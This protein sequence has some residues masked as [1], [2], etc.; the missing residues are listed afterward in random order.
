[1]RVVEYATPAAFLERVTLSL[2]AAEAENNLI[3]GVAARVHAAGSRAFVATLE[4]GG[5]LH[6]AGL[7]IGAGVEDLDV[8]QVRLEDG[9]E[10][11]HLGADDHRLRV[12]L[13]LAAV[14][15]GLPLLPCLR[16]RDQVG[17]RLVGRLIAIHFVGERGADRRLGDA[18]AQRSRHVS[19]REVTFARVEEASARP[20]PSSPT[21]RPSQRWRTA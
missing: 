11:A 5:E 21:T 12:F 9:F 20:P 18:A 15:F 6:V 19:E 3:L 10:V 4:D 1:M 14:L 8:A 2:G 13:V 7:A 16:H 17:Q